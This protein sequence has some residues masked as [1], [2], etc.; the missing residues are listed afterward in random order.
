MS[1]TTNSNNN[2]TQE[3]LNLIDSALTIQQC[4]DQKASI[5]V[6]AKWWGYTVTLNEK[7]VFILNQCLNYLDEVL[8]PHFKGVEIR[9]AISFCIQLK[10]H[11]LEKAVKNDSVRMISPWVMPFA[12][13]VVRGGS[14]RDDQNLWFTVWDHDQITWG[15]DA[16]FH[17]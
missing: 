14:S 9:R 11:R 17:D 3:Q 1:S 13:T 2:Y 5:S 12:L 15:E 8:T 10:Q 16:E 4:K 6:I 7:A